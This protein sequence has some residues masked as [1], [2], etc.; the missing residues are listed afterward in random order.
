MLNFDSNLIKQLYNHNWAKNYGDG[1]N[2]ETAEFWNQK[3]SD[4]AEKA[5]SKSQR[6]KTNKFLSRF[7]WAKTETVLDIA[8]GP[9]T[10]SIPLS[11]Q[12]KQITAVDISKNMLDVLKKQAASEGVSN[13]STL[14]ARF[15]EAKGLPCA[16]TVLCLNCL[17]L[18]IINSSNEPQLIQALLRLKGLTKKRLV[19]LVPHA[20]SV[21][22]PELKSALNQND[23]SLE[24]RRIGVLYLAMAD[25]GMMPDLTIIRRPEKL[26][27]NS[28]N[29]AC[30][31]LF[32]KSGAAELKD[33][34]AFKSALLNQL[35]ETKDGKLIYSY[36]AC[37]ALYTW[38]AL[39][40]S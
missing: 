22:T 29:E 12:V 10:Y 21:L 9:G 31:G 7:D 6:D 26:V 15:I 18:I 4:F 34:S 33:K 2:K 28:I 32:I 1:S 23:G 13:I 27:F 38:Q 11:K 40:G 5:H 36:T 17:G 3:A 24:Q 14:C 20:D 19:L 35:A 39:A 37:Q 16:D 30:E 25:C 8:S